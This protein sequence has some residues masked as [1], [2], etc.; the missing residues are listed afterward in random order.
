MTDR[1]TELRE[2]ATFLKQ[3]NG[4]FPTDPRH[5]ALQTVLGAL[6]GM[7]DAATIRPC[8]VTG[9]HTPNHHING[10]VCELMVTDTAKRML[11]AAGIVVKDLPH[12][13]H[14]A[15][16][17]KDGGCGWCHDVPSQQEYR[18]RLIESWKW[19]G[20]EPTPELLA[21]A[22]DAVREGDTQMILGMLTDDWTPIQA[23]QERFNAAVPEQYTNDRL[24]KG[25]RLL[26]ESGQAERQTYTGAT[27][28]TS[29][30]SA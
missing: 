21:P 7:L 18:D 3:E 26:E 4:Y 30:V 15:G 20:V 28:L 11:A 16:A 27:R 1:I 23:L 2:A 24:Y 17:Y 25:I 10:S 9:M 29:E 13:L 22:N 12:E 8:H 19:A 6:E 5:K 14:P